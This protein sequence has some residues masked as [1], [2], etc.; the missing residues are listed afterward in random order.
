MIGKHTRDLRRLISHH[1]AGHA[2]AA[3]KLG[4]E[5]I[6]VDMTPNGNI[7]AKV[8]THSATWVAL[9]YGLRRRR[10]VMSEQSDRADRE[11]IVRI[12]RE[13]EQRGIQARGRNMTKQL[14]QD[15]EE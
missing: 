8:R 4:L 5:I 12:A 13:I 6:G 11:Q 14:D 9:Q 2:V 3:R 1:E 15:V 7:T 10:R